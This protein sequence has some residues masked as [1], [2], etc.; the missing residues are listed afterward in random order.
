[1]SRHRLT[2]APAYRLGARVVG[3]MSGYRDSSVAGHPSTWHCA[4]ASSPCNSPRFAGHRHRAT[5]GP[6]AR[7]GRALSMCATSL[8]DRPTPARP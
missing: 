8:N 4:A 6:S 5:V 2:D 1:M 3:S 7:S